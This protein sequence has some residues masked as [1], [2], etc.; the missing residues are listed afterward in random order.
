MKRGFDVDVA[1]EMC[2]VRVAPA[3]IKRE[4]ELHVLMVVLNSTVM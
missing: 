2:M 1:W 4:L 3:E